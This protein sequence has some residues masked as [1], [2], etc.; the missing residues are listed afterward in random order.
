[1]KIAKDMIFKS[2]VC[3]SQLSDFKSYNSFCLVFGHDDTLLPPDWFT[4]ICSL[5]V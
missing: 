4:I 1:M 2:M 5:Q 3:K